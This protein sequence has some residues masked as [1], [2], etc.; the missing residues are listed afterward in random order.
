[1]C[2]SA[3]TGESVNELMQRVGKFVRT[4]KAKD[5]LSLSSEEAG[6][7]A[8][9]KYEFMEGPKKLEQTI[10]L[11][12]FDRGEVPFDDEEDYLEGKHSDIPK[13][14]V[15]RGTNRRRGRA[16][17]PSRYAIHASERY[18]GQYRIVGR[19][20]ERIANTTAFDYPE[21]VNRFQRILLDMGVGETLVKAGATGGE[22]S[23]RPR[24]GLVRIT[25]PV[26]KSSAGGFVR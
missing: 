9:V 10:D 23:L 7:E 15:T 11:E 3:L 25:E 22:H 24:E 14:I 1:M 8:A 21:A 18:P 26:A 16:T 17:I 6:E 19:Q 20:I 12:A 13:L 2:V 4:V 5:N